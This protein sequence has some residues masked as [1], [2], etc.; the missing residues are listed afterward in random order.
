VSATLHGDA[1]R[2]LPLWQAA[3]QRTQAGSDGF[4]REMT[5][6]SLVRAGRAGEAAAVLGRGF[7]V[8]E[9]PD[10]L[11]FDF[12][13][14]PDLLYARA[15]ALAGHDETESRRLYDLYLRY[16]GAGRDRY[17]ELGRARA[18]SRL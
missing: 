6:L 1:A 15:A 9:T 13:V 4:E 8:I 11:L 10:R 2:A 17:G 16:A 12:L 18:A 14:Y 5:A 3:L 7:A